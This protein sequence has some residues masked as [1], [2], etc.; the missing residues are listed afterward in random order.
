LLRAVCR[1]HAGQTAEAVA[2]A[3]E[4]WALKWDGGSWYDF[5]RVYALAAAADPDKQA[6]YGDKA[7][8]SVRKAI[9]SGFTDVTSLKIVSDLKAVRDRDDFKKLIADLDAKRK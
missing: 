5:A 8:E 7:V 1:A 4:L 9:Q 3:A 6:E 2:E